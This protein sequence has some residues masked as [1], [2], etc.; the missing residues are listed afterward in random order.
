MPYTSDVQTRL[1][2]FEGIMGAVDE[3]RSQGAYQQ[4]AADVLRLMDKAQSIGLSD[5]GELVL[6]EG[7]DPT[8]GPAV[9]ALHTD[10][11]FRPIGLPGDNLSEKRLAQA[12]AAQSGTECTNMCH[13]ADVETARHGPAMVIVS[14]LPVVAA[15]GSNEAYEVEVPRVIVLGGEEELPN[16]VA[17]SALPHELD[18]WEYYL[19]NAGRLQSRYGR[20]SPSETSTITEKRAYRTSYYVETAT[21]AYPPVD[22]ASF[23]QHNQGLHPR[24][25]EL[26]NAF[27]ELCPA[28][29]V[30]ANFKDG[31]PM[32]ILSMGFTALYGVPG[33]PVT[34][35]EQVAYAAYGLL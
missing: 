7:Y 8:T 30:G 3:A 1:P 20:Y 33:Q 13:L 19:N 29:A 26:A 28:D 16:D 23:A 12:I 35:H 10:E 31:I 14:G 15:D 34:T 2:R 22:F 4:V 6:P 21:G 11:Q 18:H 27:E 25:D 32:S 24:S 9:L 5:T 17:I